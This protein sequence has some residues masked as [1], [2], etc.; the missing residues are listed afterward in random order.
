MSSTFSLAQNV[1]KKWGWILTFGILQVLL[2]LFAV[3]FVGFTSFFSVLAIGVIFM[4]AGIS[5]SIY[6]IRNRE[7]GD[8]WF[9]LLV[10]VLTAV[11][12]FFIYNNPL[13][14]LILLT[15]LIATLFL[16][17]GVATLIGCLV[18]RFSNWGWFA[19]N[20]L[21]SV[22]AGYLILRNPVTTGIWLIGFLVGVQMMFRGLAWISLGWSGRHFAPPLNRPIHVN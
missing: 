11:C 21:I 6:A 15:V 4:I 14:N 3:G 18:E 19:I 20:G 8:M 7:L 10:G 17:T 12:G 2:G 13:E 5:E 1:Q 9:H 16:V 22:L